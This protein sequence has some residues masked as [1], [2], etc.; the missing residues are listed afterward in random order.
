MI[1]DITEGMDGTDL[2]AGVIGRSG[3]EPSP[4]LP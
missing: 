1:R 2:R 4:W 3:W